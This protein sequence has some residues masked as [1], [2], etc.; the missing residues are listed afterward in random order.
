[1]FKISVLLLCLFTFCSCSVQNCKIKPNYKEIG[2]SAL[3]NT[4]NLTEIEVRNGQV[5][6]IY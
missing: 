2:E 6:C 4:T 1:M 3:K 5:T